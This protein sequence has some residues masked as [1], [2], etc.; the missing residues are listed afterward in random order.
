MR[1][2]KKRNIKERKFK[3]EFQGQVNITANSVLADLK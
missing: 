2:N 1:E 3:L